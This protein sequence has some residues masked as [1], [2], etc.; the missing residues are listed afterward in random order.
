MQGTCGLFLRHRIGPWEGPAP[1]TP[2]TA[3]AL[4]VWLPG[5]AG[6]NWTA[7]REGDDGPGSEDGP[8]TGIWSRDEQRTG[9]ESPA[10]ARRSRQR[11]TT[12]AEWPTKLRPNVAAF[13][14]PRKLLPYELA[15]E[16]LHRASSTWAWSSSAGAACTVLRAGP[17]TVAAPRTA[18][19]QPPHSAS[20]DLLWCHGESGPRQTL[21]QHHAASSSGEHRKK[22]KGSRRGLIISLT[23]PWQWRSPPAT[24]LA[25][26][27]PTISRR[28]EKRRTTLDTAPILRYLSI[29]TRWT[30]GPA[31]LPDA[32]GEAAGGGEGGGRN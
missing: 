23:T 11:R 5:D 29:L 18:P 20:V 2:A 24:T 15:S 25:G 22:N 31:H 8:A 3:G 10:A 28:K 32:A 4:P 16:R 13:N 19:S 7:G 21:G 27:L 6:K 9:G 30:T 14:R 17:A 12:A 1:E 26:N